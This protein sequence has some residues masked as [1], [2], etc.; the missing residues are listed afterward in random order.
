MAKKV[1][2]KRLTFRVKASNRSNAT[3]GRII[4][5]ATQYHRAIPAVIFS[6]E[7]AE[8]LVDLLE[9]AYSTANAN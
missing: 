3:A 9:K 6:P 8:E 5:D 1:R 2:N 7:K 4:I